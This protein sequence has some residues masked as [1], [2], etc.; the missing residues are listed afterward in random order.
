[1]VTVPIITNLEYPFGETCEN[2]SPQISG[3]LGRSPG[4]WGLCMRLRFARLICMGGRETGDGFLWCFRRDVV[5]KGMR[6][7]GFGLADGVV[8]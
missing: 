5:L 7:G 1:M 4:I 6:K 3:D 2:S 8:R